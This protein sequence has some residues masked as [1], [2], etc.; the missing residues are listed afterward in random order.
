[1]DVFVGIKVFVGIGVEVLLGVAVLTGVTLITDMFDPVDGDCLLGLLVTPVI[2][3]NTT[4]PVV[5]S[6]IV[7][8]AIT[9]GVIVIGR[10]AAAVGVDVGVNQF[11]MTIRGCFSNT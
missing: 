6:M 11:P 4:V 1:M 9:A 10:E 7:L 8:D 5:V 3:T 2:G